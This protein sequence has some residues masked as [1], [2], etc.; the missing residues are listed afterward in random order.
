MNLKL[1]RAP[2][3]DGATI[4]QLSVDGAFECYTCEDVERPAGEK[5][6]GKTAIPRGRYRVII[7]FSN[8]FQR[9]LPLLVDV[10]GFS[11]IRIHPGN[12]AADTEGCILPGKRSQAAAVGDSRLAFAS[13]FLK[14]R[15][16]LDRGEDVFI[17][18][19][20]Q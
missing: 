2:S 20:G 11:G 5:V 12:T 19:S 7:S 3:F 14:I 16:A 8:R 17:D 10:P 1:V 4:G 13:L 15:A 6:P 9:D 18:V